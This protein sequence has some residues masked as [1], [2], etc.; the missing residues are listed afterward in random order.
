MVAE[1]AVLE[2]VVVVGDEMR[3]DARIAKELGDGVIEGLERPPA[4][5][6]EVEPAGLDV[7]ARRHAGQAPHEVPVEH[8]RATGEP[9]EVRRD[10]SARGIAGERVPVERVEEEED[11][12]HEVVG[13]IVP[14][15]IYDSGQIAR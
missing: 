10:A 7:A 3:V 15:I 2:V 9:L 5:M 8:H 14:Y 11:G 4:T 13:A 1:P 12:L 6:Q